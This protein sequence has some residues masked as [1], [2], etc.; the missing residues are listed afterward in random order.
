M[1]WKPFVR[2]ALAHSALAIPGSS[3]EGLEQAAALEACADIRETD[4]CVLGGDIYVWNGTRFR[5]KQGWSL[6]RPRGEEWGSFR[7]RSIAAAEREIA[8]EADLPDG[9]QPVFVLVCSNETETVKYMNQM[10]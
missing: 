4:A 6:D 8:R 10:A 2:P 1:D 3:S 9:E 7:E 5:S